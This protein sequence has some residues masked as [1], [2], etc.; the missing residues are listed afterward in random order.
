MGTGNSL[1]GLVK[2]SL[3]VGGMLASL[4]ERG[5]VFPFRFVA[6]VQNGACLRG[7]VVRGHE[8]GVD[9]VWDVEDVP[10]E[11]LQL[12]IH[13]LWLDSKGGDAVHVQ[14]DKSG[15]TKF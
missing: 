5:K 2:L 7:R 9:P 15:A 1:E 13:M 11:G 14:V 12:P 6:F 3:A 8:D 4:L 10:D